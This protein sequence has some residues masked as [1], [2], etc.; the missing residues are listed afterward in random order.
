MQSEKS[1]RHHF[2]INFDK[3]EQLS[4]LEHTLTHNQSP[5]KWC[6]RENMDTSCRILRNSNDNDDWSSIFFFRFCQRKQFVAS[7]SRSKKI[8]VFL[9]HAKMREKDGSKCSGRR[10]QFRSQ[11]QS[12]TILRQL[13]YVFVPCARWRVHENVKCTSAS[14][15]ADFDDDGN[16]DDDD[17]RS[18]V[19]FVADAAGMHGTIGWMDEIAS[20]YCVLYTHT[21]KFRHTCCH[22]QIK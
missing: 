21:H 1:E 11:S 4:R 7:F 19:R 16:D 3:F 22:I 5:W 9:F 18:F 13:Y 12:S 15:V 10:K 8:I 20:R 6:L 14:S 2:A 17:D